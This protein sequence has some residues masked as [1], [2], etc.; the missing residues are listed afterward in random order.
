MA[1]IECPECGSSISDKAMLC[2]Q[3]GFS[4]RGCFYCFEYR[5]QATLF[6]LPLVH[7]V[8]GPALDP[9][10]ARL[11]VAKGIVAIGG[12]AV[13]VLSLG[14]LSLGLISLGGVAIGLAALG[15]CAFG[16]LLAIGGLAVGLVAIGGGTVGYYALGGGA[17]GNHAL[18][19][20]QQDPE[21]IE[22]FKRYLG[23]W[24]EQLHQGGKP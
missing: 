9:S 21:A 14:G 18:G 4:R 10:T 13:G 23:S 17:W 16:L 11:R 8:L 5:S 19:G 20:N 6:G 7:I 22:F 12:I 1:L 24:V 15:G 3:C 2:P